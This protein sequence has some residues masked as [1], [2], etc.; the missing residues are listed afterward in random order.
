M[1]HSSQIPSASSIVLAAVFVKRKLVDFIF[2]INQF[3]WLF[4][5]R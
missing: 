5:M 1:S 3:R 4:L 2:N